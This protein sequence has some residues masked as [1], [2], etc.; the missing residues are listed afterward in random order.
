MRHVAS[1]LTLTTL[2]T[3]WLLICPAS[4]SGQVDYRFT[5]IADVE[6]SVGG[7][8]IGAPAMNNDGEVAFGSG[9]GDSSNAMF[10]MRGDGFSLTTIADTSG[11][12]ENFRHSPRVSINDSG[13]VAFTAFMDD[14]NTAIFTGDGSTLT[15]IVETDR[16]RITGA[17][18][19]LSTPKIINDGTIGFGGSV[20]V[21]QSGASEGVFTA[22]GDSPVDVAMRHTDGSGVLRTGSSTPI[23]MNDRGD[24]TFSGLLS[25]PGDELARAMIS[26]RV[27]DPFNDYDILASSNRIPFDTEFGFPAIN[28]AGTVVFVAHLRD[29]SRAIFKNDDGVNRRFVDT[30]G[31]LRAL[32]GVAIN[33]LG[34]VAYGAWLDDGR[35]GIFTG[36]DPEAGMVVAT[37]DVLNGSVVTRLSRG[38]NAEGFN[39]AGQI[40][41]L[42]Q[43]D[44]SRW[45][46]FRADPFVTESVTRWTNPAVGDDAGDWFDPD[47]W[48]PVGIP[49]LIT[50]VTIDN[51]GQANVTAATATGDVNADVLAVG[52]NGLRGILTV[53]GVDVVTEGDFEVGQAFIE[54]FTFAL[55]GLGLA[56]LADADT[57]NIGSD[58]AVGKA[59]T[60]EFA[61]VATTGS[62][63]VEDVGS[64]LIDDD[65]EIGQSVA[66]GNSS[67]TSRGFVTIVDTPVVEIG[68]G[69]SVG[70]AAAAEGGT[71]IAEGALDVT[72][73]AEILIG[74]GL[75]I[76]EATAT[77][78]ATVTA[79]GVVNVD[80]MDFNKV[81]S[82]EVAGDTAVG[83]GEARD[84]GTAIADGIWLLD[85]AGVVDIEDDLA[86]GVARGSGNAAATAV[87]RIEITGRDI[88]AGSVVI[89][90]DV[91]IGKALFAD[92]ANVAATGEL[93]ISGFGSL[94]VD[95][96]FEVGVAQPWIAADAVIS[97]AHDAS[98]NGQANLA[99]IATVAL[100]GDVNIGTATIPAG[101]GS[102]FG[103]DATG[104][105][106]ARRVG[107]VE[108]ADS[109]NVGLITSNSGGDVIGA[110]ATGEASIVGVGVL[111]VGADVNAGVADLRSDVARAEVISELTIREFEG[112]SV[113]G[114]LNLGQSAS[115]TDEEGNAAEIELLAVM[116][117]IDSIGVGGAVAVGVAESTD[118]GRMTVSAEWVAEN[119]KSFSI[120]QNLE[121]G[122]ARSNTSETSPA[123][124]Q[125]IGMASLDGGGGTLAIG[126]DL[127]VSK[128]FIT[129]T[130]GVE[131]RGVLAVSGFETM[132][133]AGVFEVG[134]VE[135]SRSGDVLIASTRPG[136]GAS[137]LSDIETVTL[138]SDLN[139]GV[140]TVDIENRVNV[141]GDVVADRVEELNV[142]GDVNVGRIDSTTTGRSNSAAAFGAF[143]VTDADMK[144]A[145]DLNIAVGAT[146]PLNSETDVTGVARLSRVDLT[147]DGQV[148]VGRVAGGFGLREYEAG[149][150]LTGSTVSASA[151]SVAE[152]A[153]GAD[154]IGQVNVTRSLISVDDALIL[155]S[156]AELNF[157]IDGPARGDD[158]GAVDVGGITVLDGVLNVHI[159]DDIEIESVFD[160]L[161][162]DSS[163]PIIGA[164]DE[165]N[166]T[167]VDPGEIANAGV[168]SVVLGGRDVDVFRVRVVPDDIRPL[169]DGDTNFDDRVDAADLNVIA[170]NWQQMVANATG[171]DFTGDGF[172]DAA[173]FNI[174]ALNWLSGVE[175]PLSF[176]AALLSHP[177]LAAIPE[178]ASAIVLLGMGWVMIH[179]QRH[180]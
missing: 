54:G 17:F 100:D 160:L 42:A 40:A 132:A 36:T 101:S 87:G 11:P 81:V 143:R 175:S 23:H 66:N 57:V 85:G 137:T 123:D 5:K 131:A 59:F 46:V 74:R 109:L 18:S 147:V 72:H 2:T 84:G 86:G 14:S 127:L 80:D 26:R 176:E 19:N 156:Q 51:G 106:D 7:A 148:V 10:I 134:A 114:D 43:L 28:D 16:S 98:A 159:D 37:G 64:F 77:N 91:E 27:D 34:E 89:G 139:I 174:L 133:V 151:L 145:G 67:A 58:V 1:S 142:T 155:G 52:P 113:G 120:G 47:N 172:V 29:D 118:R 70:V 169:I 90:E 61:T 153:A 103:I 8:A 55:S 166:I 168:E 96:Q 140:A 94:H 83:V 180:A 63:D 135:P 9:L 154:S 12:I 39:D 15:P 116:T 33:N 6:T 146:G 49:G 157:T 163:L 93:N 141:T 112:L 30:T 95:D 179:R 130:G 107:T 76:G 110:T 75:S 105:L 73:V 152:V 122:V 119:I 128:A 170:L 178:P 144:I 164:F 126:G 20:W 121:V 44:N 108:I 21:S 65:L 173:D 62:L 136:F 3:G 32:G 92:N 13:V 102:P 69:V 22:H 82:V 45:T 60:A 165:V 53:A 138:G 167:G 99:D 150:T 24:M 88:T 31:P 111:T 149:L 115:T 25:R 117:N 35:Q 177:Q 4:V 41:F 68:R 97:R 56:T 124:I 48:D 79:S 38:M 162:L 50:S 158:Y 129:P 171:G 125:A 78:N 71:T 104:R 161:L